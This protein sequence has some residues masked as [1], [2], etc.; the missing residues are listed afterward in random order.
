MPRH[1]NG[2]S[3][4][5]ARTRTQQGIRLDVADGTSVTCAEVPGALAYESGLA[6]TAYASAGITVPVLLA[7]APSPPLI[8]PIDFASNCSGLS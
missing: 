8:R 7:M 1:A 5:T 3:Q 4:V 6:G 2:I